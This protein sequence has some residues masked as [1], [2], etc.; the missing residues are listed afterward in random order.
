[1]LILIGAVSEWHRLFVPS[2]PLL[3]IMMASV[4]DKLRIKGSTTV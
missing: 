1:M 3:F 4:A 2:M